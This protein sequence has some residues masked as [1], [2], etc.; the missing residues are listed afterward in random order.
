MTNKSMA[1][2]IFIIDAE[3]HRN[4]KLKTN[5]T[6]ISNSGRENHVSPVKHFEL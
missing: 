5:Q 1:K 2:S 4:H 3:R 6:S